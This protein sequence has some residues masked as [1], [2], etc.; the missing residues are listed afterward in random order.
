MPVFDF[1]RNSDGAKGSK[2]LVEVNV[3][4]IHPNPYQPRATFDEE[5]IAELAQS[6]QQ[7]GL[8]QPLLVRKVDDG[9]EL[10]AGERRLRAVTSLG[11]EKVACIVQQDIEDESSAMMALIENLQREDLHYLEEAQCYQKLLETYGL[12]QEELANRLGKSQSSIANKLRLLKLSDEVKAAMT[13]KRLSE[14]H[15]RALLKLTD[16]K[17]RLDAVERIAEKG[18]SVK[19]TE[20]MVEKTLN[21]AYDEKQ[22][23]AKPRPKLMRIVRDYRLFMNTINQ[24]VNQLRESGMTVE[25]EQSDRADG[26]DI[27][28]SVTRK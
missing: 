18:L 9:Y 4:S 17:Q 11:M 16:D 20:Q 25:V 21:K 1:I 6:I 8:L 24:A 2:R 22:D 10:V 23:G 26:V 13:E 14:R 5:S 27:K 15:A 28:I 19:E 7:V 3:A 12:T